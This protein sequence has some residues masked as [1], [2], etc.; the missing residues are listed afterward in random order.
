MKTIGKLKLTQLSK[1]DLV[2]RQMNTLKGRGPDDNTCNCGCS[3]NT[4]E[5]NRDANSEYGYQCSAGEDKYTATC[6]CETDQSMANMRGGY[7]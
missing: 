1:A 5:N 4:V 7:L 6:T 2:K 3:Y